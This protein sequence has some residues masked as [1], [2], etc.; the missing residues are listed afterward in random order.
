[1][2]AVAVTAYAGAAE[3]VNAIVAGFQMHLAKPV[4][5][6]ELIAIVASLARRSADY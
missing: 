6:A 4:E 2:P 3:R 1:M 5:P